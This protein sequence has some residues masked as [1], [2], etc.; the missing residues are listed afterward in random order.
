MVY[1]V[2][3]LDLPG[4]DWSSTLRTENDGKAL[5]Y[6]VAGPENRLV[7]PTFE[8][9]LA[10][11]E[12]PS[13]CFCDPLV[14]AGPAGAGKSLLVRGIVRRW[15]QR[16]GAEAVGYYTAVD[17]GRQL[18]DARNE[19]N[20]SD[21]RH[22][23]CELRLLVV[24]DIHRLATSMFVQRELR[25]TLDTLAESG[26]VV[27]LTSVQPPA[28]QA[29][30]EA[31][32]RD[33]L[34]GGLTIH[35]RLP[36]IEARTKILQVVAEARGDQLDATQLQTLAQSIQGPAPRLLQ[37][38]SQREMHSADR[39][40]LPGLDPQ[41]LQFKQIIA[42]VARYFSLTQA[43]IR[44]PARRKSLVYARGITIYLA[45][46]LTDLTYTQIGQGLGGRDHTTIMHAQQ[47][48]EELITTDAN[49]QQTIEALR[50]ILTSV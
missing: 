36:G 28:I 29:N 49:T 37:G 10:G 48:T 5:R 9:L 25:D 20:L 30:L 24:E 40:A 34:S 13:G 6:F 22:Q 21:F 23:L 32:L 1:G 16:L 31:G 15:A 26:S 33:R 44:S 47:R 11:E 41:P 43:A 3:L 7:V 17:F 2:T 46:M 42:L 50:R 35:L 45:R 8:R 27:V 12:L 18:R 14:L 4:C 38:L 19:G 39:R